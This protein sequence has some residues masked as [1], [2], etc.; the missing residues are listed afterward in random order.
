MIE[1][2]SL[3]IAIL[4]LVGILD[5]Y[6]AEM[7]HSVISTL[8]FHSKSGTAVEGPAPPTLNNAF[9]PPAAGCEANTWKVKL[10]VHLF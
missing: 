3:G 9:L 6:S 7:T 4:A 5:T 1:V 8:L 10:R 2:S